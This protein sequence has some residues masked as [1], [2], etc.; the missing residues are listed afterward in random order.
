M[1]NT[2][3]VDRQVTVQGRNFDADDRGKDTE[4][5]GEVECIK[6]E[7]FSLAFRGEDLLNNVR[8]SQT[9]T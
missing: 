7:H 9:T 8:I 6:V 3:G 1:S 5:T 4:A 2:L